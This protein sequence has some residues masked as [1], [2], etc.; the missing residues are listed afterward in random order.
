[1]VP[2][3]DVR[4]R[5]DC[6]MGSDGRRPPYF[7]GLDLGGTNIK[8]GVVDD[9]GRP[10][11]LVSGPTR[12][13]LGPEAGLDS[14]VEVAGRAVEASGVDWSEI[15]AVGLGSAGTIDTAGGRIVEATNLPLW[16]GFPIA[17]RLARTTESAHLPVE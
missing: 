14:L 3:I 10:W 2:P 17:A 4:L 5:E 13:E 8:A 7:L 11:P 16:N 1:M 12:A 9:S 15:A 6:N